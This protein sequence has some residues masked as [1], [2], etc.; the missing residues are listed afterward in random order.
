MKTLIAYPIAIKRAEAYMQLDT[1]EVWSPLRPFVA[2]NEP[3]FWSN[4]YRD[5]ELTKLP[6]GETLETFVNKAAGGYTVES[7]TLG[8][9]EFYPRIWR[10]GEGLEQCGDPVLRVEDT[11]FRATFV[12]SLEQIEGLFDDLLSIFRVV[13]PAMNNLEAYGGAIRDII[14]LA[15]TEV[16]AQWKGVLEAN[17]VQPSASYFK[18]SDYVRLLPTMKLEQYAVGLIRYPRI[19]GT[20]PFMGGTPTGPRSHCPGTLHITK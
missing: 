19:A 18:T 13:H 4:P 16:E 15:C 14:I 5:P 3:G 7:P 20:A 11:S 10:T 9:G 2:R 17:G 8:A 6:P 1:G 12:N